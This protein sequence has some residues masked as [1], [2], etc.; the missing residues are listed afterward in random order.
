MT[1]TE[2][3]R[4]TQNQERDEKRQQAEFSIADHIQANPA[5][6]DERTG[7]VKIW[8]LATQEYIWRSAVDAAEAISVGSAV[9]QR[10]SE[11]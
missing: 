9:L 2:E 1:R 5:C 8:E 7:Q 4:V 11:D 3:K 10:P 6:W